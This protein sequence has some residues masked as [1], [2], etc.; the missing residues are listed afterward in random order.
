MM[1]AWNGTDAQL[2]AGMR[3]LRGE[4]C[5]LP[6]QRAL[7]DEVQRRGLMKFHEWPSGHWA[8]THRG[9]NFLSGLDWE[10]QP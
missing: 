2:A 9:L 6:H 7:A 1:G 3:T 5:T 4:H 8:V 10:Q